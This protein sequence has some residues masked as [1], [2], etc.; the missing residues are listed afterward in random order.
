MVFVKRWGAVRL[1]HTVGGEKGIK[2]GHGYPETAKNG[3]LVEPIAP[4]I[5]TG[6]ALN[7]FCWGERGYMGNLAI[8]I[9]V[10]WHDVENKFIGNP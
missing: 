5:V 8:C 1:V 7:L 10:G 9:E 3:T 6:F 4:P 2:D